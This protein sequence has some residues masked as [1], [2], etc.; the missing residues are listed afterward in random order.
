MSKNAE[1]DTLLND[2]K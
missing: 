1:K 2:V